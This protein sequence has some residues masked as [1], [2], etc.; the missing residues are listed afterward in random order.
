[1]ADIKEHEVEWFD[2]QHVQKVDG[3]T[4]CVRVRSKA[5]TIN[6]S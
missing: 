2:V 3:G 4:Y 1:M 6:A 5:S